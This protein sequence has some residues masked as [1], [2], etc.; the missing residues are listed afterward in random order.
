MDFVATPTAEHF[1][2]DSFRLAEHPQD[3]TRVFPDG[4]VYVQLPD[5][6]S[7]DD[8]VVIH[9]GQPD[10][11]R[12]LSY[13]YATLDVLREHDC[14]TE[15]VFTYVPYCRQDEAFY[16]G[17][18][19]YA[20]SL[21]RSVIGCYEVDHVY[22]VDPHFGH[23]EW[24]QEFPVTKL[25]T[26]PLVRERVEMDEYAVV[27]PD[28]GAVERFGI[29]GFEKDRTGAYDVELT[30]DLD[31]TDRNVLVFDDLIATGGTMVDTYHRLKEQGAETVQAA[32][33]HGV[34][35]EGV[36]R[37]Q[38]TYDALYLTNTIENDAANVRVEPL[39]EGVLDRDP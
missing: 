16:E 2:V 25:E 8:A 31:V 13:L 11:N 5:V 35:E 27:G 34:L 15:L 10:P 9:A 21:L 20:R 33:V 19:N 37:V 36:H 32:A 24:I 30:G 4:E 18:L 1:D 7:I 6:G 26:F 12:G 38:E 29:P 23:R 17:A 39:L 14:T 28:L 3:E 22:A